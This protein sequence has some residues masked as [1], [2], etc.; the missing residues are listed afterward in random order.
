M[1]NATNRLAPR[2]IYNSLRAKSKGMLSPRSE[3]DTNQSHGEGDRGGSAGADE[4]LDDPLPA[5]IVGDQPWTD[6]TEQRHHVQMW[7]RRGEQRFQHII[8]HQAHGNI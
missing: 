7:Q 8:D 2:A 4:R 5:H 6:K 3:L 1:A